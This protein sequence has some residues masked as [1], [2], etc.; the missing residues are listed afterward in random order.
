MTAHSR[1]GLD[2]ADGGNESAGGDCCEFDGNH[3]Y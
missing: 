2:E 1:G 3:F